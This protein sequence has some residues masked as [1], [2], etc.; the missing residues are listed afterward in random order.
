MS[1][2]ALRIGGKSYRVACAPGEETRVERLG[3]TIDDK[4]ASMGSLS[5]QDAQNM[6]F[7]ALL[8]ADEVH[9]GRDAVARADGVAD[10]AQAATESAAREREAMQARMDAAQA[11]AEAARQDADAALAA[12]DQLRAR[13][14][15]QEAELARLRG[16]HLDAARKAEAVDAKLAKAT[17]QLAAQ[18]DRAAGLEAEIVALK[19]RPAPAS[20]LESSGEDVAP[21]LERFAEMLEECAD[22]LER[23]TANT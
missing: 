14:A 21:A 7:A 19:A 2:V 10:A 8:L 16:E 20:T 12:R 5:G 1:E 13:F 9:E 15:D 17:E 6:L 22:K 11:E 3:A 4:L 23:R 18:A